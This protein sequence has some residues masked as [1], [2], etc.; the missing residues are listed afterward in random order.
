MLPE[1]GDFGPCFDR[2]I[3]KIRQFDVGF[4]MKSLVGA[5]KRVSGLKPSS[6]A[7][8]AG[9]RDGDVISYATG[10]DALQ[11]DVTRT[12]TVQVTRDG[13]TFPV[14]YLPRGEAVDAYQWERIPGVPEKNCK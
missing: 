4:D 2:T 3:K 7:A 11:G 14:T 6:E 5:E 12:F 8:K 9:I 13:K 1:P 10:L